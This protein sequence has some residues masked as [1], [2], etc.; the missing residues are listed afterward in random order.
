ML[1]RFC[2]DCGKEII[3]EPSV[4][5]ASS[6]SGSSLSIRAIKPQT[7]WKATEKPEYLDLH[8]ACMVSRLRTLVAMLR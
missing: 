6:R 1:K 8:D 4:Y 7:E 3:D 5:R 2:D